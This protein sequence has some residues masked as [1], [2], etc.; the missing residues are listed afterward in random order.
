M[1]EY[2]LRTSNM[3]VYILRCVYVFMCVR[4]CVCMDYT[5]TSDGFEAAKRLQFQL[6]LLS[7]ED[8]AIGKIVE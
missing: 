7:N 1:Y 8:S 4:A 3:S 5:S 2:A 6:I